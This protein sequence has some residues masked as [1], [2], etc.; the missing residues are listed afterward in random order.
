MRRFFFMLGLIFAGEAIFALPF[1]VT[2]FFRGTFLEVFSLTDTQLGTAQGL[3]GIAAM[4]A[5][6]PGGPIADRFSARKLLALSL[7]ATA[8]GGLYMATI[9]GYW[10]VC[11]LWGFFGFSTIFLFWAPL[12]RATRYWGSS[13]TQGRAYGILEGGRGAI[14][15][16]AAAIATFGLIPEGAANASVGEKAQ[17]LQLIIFGYCALT[18]VTAALVFFVVPGGGT[19]AADQQKTKGESVFHHVA[20]AVSIPAVWMQALIIICA[21]VSYKGFDNYGLFAEQA[22]GLDRSSAT[23]VVIA[24]S[25]MRPAAA[26]AAGLVGD[27][28]KSSRVVLMAFLIMLTS[29]SYFAFVDPNPGAAWILVINALFGATAIFGVRGVY[30][31]LFG[32]AKVPTEV[33]GTAV[34][35][36]SI[37]GYTPDVFV[38]YVQGKLLDASPGVSGHQHFFLFLA[39]FALTGV[40]ATLAFGALCRTTSAVRAS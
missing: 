14:A 18:L 28:M 15:A 3:Y 23:W 39:A 36:V 32:E 7:V 22:Y 30:F 19:D 31:A 4:V 21:Y 24:A 13:D 27:R 16:G 11:A 37:I 33:T 34:G 20:R 6:F 1:H 5:Y 25:L 35:F 8:V 10:G 17:T 29:H 12:L 38:G 9:P 40:L 2:R 26:V